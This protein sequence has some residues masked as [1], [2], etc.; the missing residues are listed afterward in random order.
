M[1]FPKNFLWG[2]ATAANQCEGAWNEDGKGPSVADVMTAGARNVPRRITDTVEEGTYYP[3]HKAIDHYHRYKEDIALFAEMGFTCYRFSIAWSRIFP[4][5]TEAE[6]NEA[7]LKHYDDVIDTCRSYGIEPLITISHYEMPLGLVR[8]GGWANRELVD[9]FV[10]YCDVIFRRYRGRVKLWLTFNEINCVAISPWKCAGMKEASEEQK[11]LAAYHQFLASA[12]AVKLAHAIDPE[13]QV[14]MMYG[15]IFSYPNCCDPDDV[16]RNMEFMHEAMYYCDVQCRG[17]Y[18]EYKLRDLDRKGIRLPIQEGDLKEI[19]EGTVDFLSYSYYFTLVC[20]KN[21][22]AGPKKG[23]DTGYRNP[24]LKESEWGWTIDPKGLRY[25]L[26]LFYDRYQIPV[27]VV[28]NGFGAPDVVEA[29]GSVH[30]PYRISYFREHIRELKKAVEIDGVPVMGY[31]TW[32]CIDLVSAGT[33]EMKKRYGFVYVDIDDEGNGTGKRLKKDSFYWYRDVIKSN[34]EW[35][36]D[37][38]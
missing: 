24:Y 26:N 37:E 9:H 11:A 22:P 31:T 16:E 3:S 33:G 14:G 28:E 13:N 10:R 8:L 29:D 6:P 5:G 7:G 23:F 25:S 17:K 38:S 27:M 36:G 35:L 21:S 2:G 18:P 12:R 19:Q 34:G 4:E 15:G 32:G 1:G 30:D 20:G